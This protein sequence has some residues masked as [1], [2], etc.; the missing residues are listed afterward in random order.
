MNNEAQESDYCANNKQERAF[1]YTDGNRIRSSNKKFM[2]LMIRNKYNTTGF[3]AL[4][5]DLMDCMGRHS[6][7]KWCTFGNC[8][9]EFLQLNGHVSV[10]NI[11]VRGNACSK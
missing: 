1:I 2:D 10:G 6:K 7:G 5:H 11:R 4:I 3:E 9:S 8:L